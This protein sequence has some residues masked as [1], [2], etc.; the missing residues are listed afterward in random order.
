MAN[1]IALSSQSDNSR[2]PRT[3]TLTNLIELKRNIIS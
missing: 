2:T 1:I 3:I